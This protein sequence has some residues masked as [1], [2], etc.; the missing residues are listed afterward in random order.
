MRPRERLLPRQQRHRLL[1]QEQH[2]V[3]QRPVLPAFQ[4]PELVAQA[5]NVD[6]VRAVEN[7]IW[8][9]RA[10]VAGHTEGLVSYRSSGIVDPDSCEGVVS[11]S[12]RRWWI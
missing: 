10:D 11:I 3:S 6:I 2:H 5:R 7:S 8:V 9:I 4:G 12:A 1:Q